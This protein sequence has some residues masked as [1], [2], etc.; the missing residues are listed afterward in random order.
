[1][2]A[3][4]A[5]LVAESEVYRQT[6]TLEVQNLRLYAL[7]AQKRA[8]AFSSSASWLLLAAPLFRSVAG[9]FFT[10]RRRFGRTR[11]ITTALLF[12]QMYRRLAPIWHQ[13]FGRDGLFGAKMRRSKGEE[14]AR[15]ASI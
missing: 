5:A 12:W 8:T 6:L 10:R 4:K 1:M 15:A 14:K 7:R 2:Q 11:L 9:S 13:L 3:R